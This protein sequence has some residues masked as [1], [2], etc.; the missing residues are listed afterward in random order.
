M[1]MAE[2]TLRA[3]EIQYRR[4]F[5]AARDGILILDAEAGDVDG[6]TDISAIVLCKCPKCRTTFAITH[7]PP[8][9]SGNFHV[10]KATEKV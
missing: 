6:L 4:L 2:Q 10:Q 1:Q 8:N 7:A 3:S 9:A 5:E